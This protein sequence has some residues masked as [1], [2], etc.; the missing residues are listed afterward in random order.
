MPAYSQ[1]PLAQKLGLKPGTRFAF[2]GAPVGFQRELPTLPDTARPVTPAA[3]E[4]DL[5]LLFAPDLATLRRKAPALIAKLP[6]AGVLWIAWPKQ[7]SGVATD[8][9]E[10]VVRATLLPTGLVDIKV[11]SINDTY[12]GLKFVRRLANRR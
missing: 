1:T 5:V 4:I 2:V 12:S 9:R 8:L 7:A 10:D 11:C 3:R 6:P